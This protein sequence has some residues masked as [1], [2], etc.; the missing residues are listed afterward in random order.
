MIKGYDSVG[1]AD[2]N[3]TIIEGTGANMKNDKKIL[4]SQKLADKMGLQVG[5]KFVANFFDG[6]V[7]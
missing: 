3:L 2:M 5:D 7:K 1:I 6:N 4:I